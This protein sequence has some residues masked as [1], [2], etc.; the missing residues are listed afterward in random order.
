MPQSRQSRPTALLFLVCTLSLCPLGL[1]RAMDADG[2]LLETGGFAKIDLK[3]P[4]PDELKIV[5]YNIRWRGGEDLRE[6]IRLLREDKEIG[7]ATVIALQEVDRNKERTSHTNTAR[8]IAQELGMNYAWA[9]PPPV[10]SKGREEEEETGVAILSVYPLSEVRRIVL[11]NEGPK[12][13]RRVA[14]GATV[15][16]DQKRSLRIYSVH[17]ETR[18]SNEKRL[19]QFTAVLDDLQTHYAQAPHSVIVGDFNTLM[20]KDVN[21]TSRLFKERGFATPFSNDDATWKTFILQ[22]KLDWMWLHGLDVKTFGID[23]DIGLSDHWPLWAVIRLQ[24]RKG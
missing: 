19:E 3:L 13:R 6:L 18:L 12:G 20:P 1:S 4:L 22:L 5:T 16:L 24:D 10:T 14:L 21:A 7:R 11:P 17:A 9:A 8:R 23:R 15:Q 2:A